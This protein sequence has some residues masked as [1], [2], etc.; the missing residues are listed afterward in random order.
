M[1]FQGVQ[2][3]SNFKKV[4]VVVH[5]YNVASEEVTLLQAQSE[6]WLSGI[7]SLEICTDLIILE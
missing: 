1:P 6:I 2:Q 3:F 7:A 5:N 4:R